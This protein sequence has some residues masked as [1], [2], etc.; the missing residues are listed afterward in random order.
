MKLTFRILSMPMTVTWKLTINDFVWTI[1]WS[2]VCKE[3]ALYSENYIT[4][5]GLLKARFNERKAQGNYGNISNLMVGTSNDVFFC[6]F[7]WL[8]WD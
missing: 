7:S 1:K 6:S 5:E 4:M 3:R 8:F 2:F